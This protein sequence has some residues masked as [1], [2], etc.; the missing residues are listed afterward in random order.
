MAASTHCTPQPGRKSG[1]T[2]VRGETLYD[3]DATTGIVTWQTAT[4][5]GIVS[6][7]AVARGWV[8]IGSEDGNVYTFNS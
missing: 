3:F 7:P 1:S 4:N 5:G 8:F 6:S 2:S